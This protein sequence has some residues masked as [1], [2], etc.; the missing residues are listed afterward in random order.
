MFCTYAKIGEKEQNYG[1]GKGGGGCRSGVGWGEYRYENLA[2]NL[3]FSCS[4]ELMRNSKVGYW[5]KTF[6]E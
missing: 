4:L 1:L 3:D 5:Q 2:P 6:A